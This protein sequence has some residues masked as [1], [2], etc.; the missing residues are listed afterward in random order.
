MKTFTFNVYN[1]KKILYAIK[2]YYS[3]VILFEKA[4]ILLQ[5]LYLIFCLI[6]QFIMLRS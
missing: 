6:F 1:K 5:H 4:H 3:S 2:R